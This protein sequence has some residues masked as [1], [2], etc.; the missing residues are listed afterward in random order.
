MRQRLC[1]RKVID[2]DDFEVT[3]V[4]CDLERIASNSA[5]SIDSDFRLDKE[6]VELSDTITC[7][8][9]RNG[10][11]QCINRNFSSMVCNRNT[12]LFL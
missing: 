11:V 7:D 4:K 10:N 9:Y 3:A 1:I 8:V 12:Y 5:E 2:R 6:R